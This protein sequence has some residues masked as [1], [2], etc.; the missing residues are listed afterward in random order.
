ME[1]IILIISAIIGIPLGLLFLALL[2]ELFD[3]YYFGLGGMWTTFLGCLATGVGIIMVAIN[4]IGLFAIP[5]AVIVLIV[6]QV[7]KKKKASFM[8]L[9]KVQ[10]TRQITPPKVELTPIIQNENKSEDIKMND[11]NEEV[12]ISPVIP[13]DVINSEKNTKEDSYY[14]EIVS[15]E[16]L[17]TLE[18]GVYEGVIIDFISKKQDGRTFIVF[19]IHMSCQIKD[20][21]KITA[22]HEVV[23]ESTFMIL[24]DIPCLIS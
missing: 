24:N 5:I 3:V 23:F 1:L 21:E 2:N 19:K 18:N 20:G 14:D 4:L 13:T 8:A 10:R 15:A 17:Q 12:T 7:K 9:T 6:M 16:E 22:D 11:T